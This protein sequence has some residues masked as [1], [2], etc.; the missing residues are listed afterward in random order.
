M[1]NNSDKENISIDSIKVI[2]KTGYTEELSQ[3]NS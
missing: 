3:I 1:Y 2:D